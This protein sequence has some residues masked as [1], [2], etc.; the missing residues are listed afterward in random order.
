MCKQSPQSYRLPHDLAPFRSGTTL[1]LS[2]S[3]LTIA[4]LYLEGPTTQ[5][6]KN[7]IP[8]MAFVAFGTLYSIISKYL[9]P[10]GCVYLLL[11]VPRLANTRTNFWKTTPNKT[12]SKLWF[13][14]C[15]TRTP[16]G[17]LQVGGQVGENGAAS[18]GLRSEDFER[19]KQLRRSN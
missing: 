5:M 12:C 19:M 6:S 18:G 8:T 13:R 9:D 1:S 4:L 7:T 14:R 17:S 15:P 16:V 2:G 10:Q 3:S 11:E